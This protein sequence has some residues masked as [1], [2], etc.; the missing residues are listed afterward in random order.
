MRRTLDA[1][2]AAGLWAACLAMAAIAALVLAQVGGRVLDRALAAAGAAPVGFAVPSLAE[3]GGFLFVASAF[4][5]LPATL[6]AGVHV[7]VTLLTGAV[8]GQAGRALTGLVLAVAA[9][10][11][12][13]AA[14][15]AGAQAWDSLAF[16]SVSYGVVAVPLWIPQGAMTLGLA[17]LLVAVL[18]ELWTLAHGRPAAF[19]AA[20]AARGEDAGGG[21]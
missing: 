20:E 19:A 10:L 12:G 21:R 3:I 7:R 6:R 13:F 1:L 15:N 5:A 4:L 2:Y 16:G 11:A 8:R 14:W 17:L 18:D 9:G